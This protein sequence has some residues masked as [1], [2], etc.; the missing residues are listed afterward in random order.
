MKQTKT[1][2]HRPASVMAGERRYNMKR[3]EA[4]AAIKAELLAGIAGET[5]RAEFRAIRKAYTADR[6]ALV[7]AHLESTRPADT[8]E[9]LAA[10]LGHEN[11]A[12]IVALMVI[13]KGDHDERISRKARTWAAELVA[14]TREDVVEILGLFYCDDIHPVH[15]DQIAR[16]M[17]DYQPPKYTTEA[18]QPAQET[19]EATEATETTTDD[20]SPAEA[21]QEGAEATETES[22]FPRIEAALE[23]SPARSAWDRGVKAY[24][25][26]LLEELETAA[27]GGWFDLD[28]LA[29]PKVLQKALLNG[30]SDWS[31]YSW[32]GCSLCYDSDI[33]R[34]LCTPTELKKTRNGER[35]PNSSEEW[36]DTQARALTQAARRLCIIIAQE[37]R[38]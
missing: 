2:P 33:A 27:A 12:E 19:T 15:L 22:P 20:E 8:V 13:V 29:A 38:A 25:A 32:G 4:A 5:D 28:D 23:A 21:A 26:E 3:Y 24:A 36:L 16:S 6:A 34:R 35:R 17:M 30:A 10:R 18:A 31:Q 7:A 11:A 37:V 1:H 14:M 9:A